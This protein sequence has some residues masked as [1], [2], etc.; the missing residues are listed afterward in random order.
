M[1][2]LAVVLLGHPSSRDVISGCTGMLPSAGRIYAARAVPPIWNIS[3]SSAVR[4]KT[5]KQ[6][7]GHVQGADNAL[8]FRLLGHSFRP[9]V[10]PH[11]SPKPV[12]TFLQGRPRT[13]DP[14]RT[15]KER[16]PHAGA[17][18]CV[19]AGAVL[20]AD[21]CRDL[22]SSCVCCALLAIAPSSYELTRNSV[23]KSVQRHP[24]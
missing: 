10:A 23:A 13:P 3:S 1:S 18:R 20:A 8:Q 19:G 9:G 16:Q 12:V 22:P 15:E 2:G 7:N 21:V 4:K 5:W 14:K 17:C 11:P 6:E 24:G